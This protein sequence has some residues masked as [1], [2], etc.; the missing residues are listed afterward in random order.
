MTAFWTGRRVRLRGIEP[1][2]WSA[3]QALDSDSDSE[4]AIDALY[5]PRS[6]E[7]YQHFSVEDSRSQPGVE[8]FR[9]A[10]ESL[11]DGA[12]VGSISTHK[13][14][15]HN[16]CFIHGIAIMAA[17][18]R[19]GYAADAM[20]IMLRYM[21][22]E[23]RFHKC[24]AHIYAYNEASVGLHTKLGFVHEGRLREH[25]FQAG[26]FHDLIVMGLTAPEFAK[27]HAPV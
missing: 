22:Q 16:G 20:V 7:R 18:Q 15:L 2:D 13:P 19:K 3:Y 4:R 12:F 11:D 5:P 6:V 24:E 14:D 23:R 9:L 27:L 25:V 8:E 1:A 21:F 10:I 17:H 26:R